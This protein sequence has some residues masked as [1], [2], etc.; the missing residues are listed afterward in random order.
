MHIM[1]MS[2]LNASPSLPRLLHLWMA[3]GDGFAEQKF[4]F[5]LQIQ[6]SVNFV[7]LKNQC[8]RAIIIENC[9]LVL[10]FPF[11]WS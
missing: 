2:T 11:F 4:H 9:S 6:Q 7:I 10:M 1:L 3:V 5:G 8:I